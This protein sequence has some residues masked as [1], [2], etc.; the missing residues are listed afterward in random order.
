MTPLISIVIPVYNGAN[1][2]RDAIDS[3]LTQTYK[4]REVIV[5]NDG[6]TDGGE[7]ESI[8]RSYGSAIRY[9]SKE[10]GGVATAVNLGI[11][12]MRGEYFAWLSHDDVFYPRKLELQ[13]E[14]LKKA[15]NEKGVSHGNFDFINTIKGCLEPVD[16]LHLYKKEQL[17]NGAFPA[18]FLAAHGS[19]LLIHKANFD[20]VGFYDEGLP[21]TQDSEFLFRVLRGQRSTFVAEPLIGARLHEE[22]GQRTMV[23]HHTEYNE[24]IHHFLNKLA[25]SEMIDMCDKEWNFYV[26]LYYLL[27]HGTPADTVLDELRQRISNLS[28]VEQD[29]MNAKKNWIQ[30]FFAEHLQSLYI[31]GAGYYGRG[32][33]AKLRFYGVEPQ[34]FLDNDM[35]KEGTIVDG[36]CC[37]LPRQVIGIKQCS[38]IVSMLKGYGEAE[39]QLRQY[40]IV[41]VPFH[42]V[43]QLLFRCED[44]HMIGEEIIHEMEK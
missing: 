6:S 39:R 33:L 32:L 9:L 35:S 43:N 8:A 17:E 27:L 12:N 23:C 10:N 34:G 41:C 40:G 21:S 22:Q 20:R 18:V 42:L 1:Y 29:E 38:V 3:A 30:H 11:R 4:E 24:M 26:Q 37:Y 44:N 19:T 2:M 15:G 16:Y 25:P 13:L 14:A 36:L 7:T 28:V 5:V 31:F